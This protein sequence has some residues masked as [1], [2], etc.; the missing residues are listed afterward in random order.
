MEFLYLGIGISSFILAL[1]MHVWANR[2]MNVMV[3]VINSIMWGLITMDGIKYAIETLSVWR[4]LLCIFM[5]LFVLSDVKRTLR[6]WNI[7]VYKRNK[8][9][10]K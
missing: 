3:N 7:A 5:V 6:L 1:F 9:N 10:K 8:L 4:A 2:T